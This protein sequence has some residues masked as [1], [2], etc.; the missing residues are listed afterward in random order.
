[1][2]YVGTVEAIPSTEGKSS[3]LPLCGVVAIIF[4]VLL[5]YSQTA[6][7]SWDEGFHVL[8]AQ[9]IARGKRPYLDFCFPQTPLNA[10]WNAGWMRIF[11]DTWHL[12]H[13]LSALSTTA[14]VLL[15]ADF[16]RTRFPESRWRLPGAATTAL[17]LGLNI[18]VV[19]YATIGQSYA[20]CL[21][22]LVAAFRVAI[23]AVDRRSGRWTGI[24]GLL[25]AS[26]A[27]SSLLTALAAP[28]LL[29]WIL[30]HAPAG[31]RWA[32]LFS[33]AAGGVIPFL[34]VIWLFCQAPRIVFF[35]LVQYQL[36]YRRTNWEDATP[37][38]V[39][40]LTSWLKSPTALI[41]GLLAVL[42]LWFVARRSEW[43]ASSRAEFY[44]CAWLALAIGAELSAT[45]PTFP[46]YF[47]L[48]T[49]F[50][51]IPAAAGLYVAA[52]RIRN[53]VRAWWPVP[54]LGVL[55]SLGLA[56]SLHEDWN[57]LAWRDMEAVARKVNEVTPANGSLWADE[58]VYFLTRRPPAEGSEFSYAEVIDL[59]QDMARSLH[60]VSDQGLAQKAAE[61]VFATVSTCEEDDV[62]ENLNL[63]RSFRQHA[64]L[65]RRCTVFWDPVAKAP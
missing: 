14:A 48:V 19:E 36:V 65:G 44:L 8:A 20:F 18:V 9:L 56:W 22:L 62:I 61:G 46:T 42:G 15:A 29:I 12:V 37:H 54:I 57:K 58:H 32:R 34:P 49:P 41:L 26:A 51:A 17:V 45:H 25:A 59:P 64:A 31:R 30:C 43:K 55:L 21:L 28:V 5:I 50:L 40:V 52:A 2:G 11:G 33:F 63:P 47:V 4:A 16:I 27:A 1:M 39:E 53:P 38:D 13:A 7:F 60:I 6:A 24:A 3:F 10:Y 35:N 23:L